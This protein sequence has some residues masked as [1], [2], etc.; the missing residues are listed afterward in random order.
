MTGYKMKALEQVQKAGFKN[1][2]QLCKQENILY[3]QLWRWHKNNPE[4]FKRF[5]EQ[6]AQR[7][8]EK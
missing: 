7:R 3:N 5:L 6:A 1:F 2:K 8:K 4:L